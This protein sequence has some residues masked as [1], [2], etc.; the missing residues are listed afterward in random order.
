LY[1]DEVMPQ[2]IRERDGF[3]PYWPGSPWGG[4]SPNSAVEGDVHDWHVWHGLPVGEVDPERLVRLFTDGPQPDDVAFLHYAEDRGR[5]IS[6]FGMH[7]SPVL[8]TLRRCIPTDQLYHHSPAMDHHNK[9]NP[10]NKGDDLML[11]VTGLPKDLEGYIDFSMIA[12]AEGLK[13]GIEHFR[14][15]KPHCSGTLVWQLNDCW[16]VLSWSL[17][18]HFGFGKAGYFYVRRAYSPVLASFKALEDGSVELWVT[19]DT[20]VDVTD[21]VVI[22]LA[23]FAGG[24][25]WEERPSVQVP[26]NTSRA[27]WRCGSDRAMGGSD[28]YLSVRSPSGRFPVNRHFFSAIKDLDRTV[29]GPEVKLSFRSDHEACVDLRASVYL[30]Y[31]HLIVPDENTRFS[32]NYLDLEPGETRTIIVTN[33]K[34][35]LAQDMISV[36]WR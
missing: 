16:P 12:Q 19:N 6:E 21:T 36:R 18:D 17:L 13:F 32:D 14:R 8:E 22:R 9:D 15:R 2:L 10:K 35:R 33:P 11:T 24:V 5:F 26:A 4:P 29:V 27:V 25:I 1:Y 34:V 7:A 20:L 30:Y 23:A 28:R 31:V 3:T